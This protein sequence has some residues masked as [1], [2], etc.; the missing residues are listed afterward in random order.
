MEK[1]SSIVDSFSLAKIQQFFDIHKKICTL[2]A[3]TCY[4]AGFYD[5]FRTPGHRSAE[6]N[7]KMDFLA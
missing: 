3:D 2:E 5:A 6:E 7:K 1:L 4:S